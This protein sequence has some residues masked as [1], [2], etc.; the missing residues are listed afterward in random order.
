M[1]SLAV[2]IIL[3]VLMLAVVALSIGVYLLRPPDPPLFDHFD[4]NHDGRTNSY[5]ADIA[6]DIMLGERIATP[7]MLERVDVNCDGL[8]DDKD[9]CLIMDA[10][11]MEVTAID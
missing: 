5:D 3:L 10:I 11:Q 1:K 7:A 8:I 2:G 4:I 9:V 6:Y